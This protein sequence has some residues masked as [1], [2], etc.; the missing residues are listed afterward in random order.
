MKKPRLERQSLELIF[1]SRK[2][3]VNLIEQTIKLLFDKGSDDKHNTGNVRQK[4]LPFT[5]EMLKKK[6]EY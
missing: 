1:L 3:H 4:V 6:K 5:N 2:N